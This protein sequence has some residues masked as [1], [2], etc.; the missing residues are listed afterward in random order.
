MRLELLDGRLSPRTRTSPRSQRR[1]GNLK[2]WAKEESLV[3]SRQQRSH[4][5]G[6]KQKIAYAGVSKEINDILKLDQCY[7]VKEEEVVDF[8]FSILST[9][10]ETNNPAPRAVSIPP[11]ISIE[12]S[13]LRNRREQV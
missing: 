3:K 4:N 11:T 5:Y 7:A 12:R 6:Q 9:M 10:K 13:Q 8:L 1:K 2:L